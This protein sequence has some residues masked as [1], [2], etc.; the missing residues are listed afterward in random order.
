MAGVRLLLPSRSNGQQVHN[1]SSR[2]YT[3]NSRRSRHPCSSI[4]LH[5]PHGQQVHRRPHA[6]SHDAAEPITA[7]RPSQ[8]HHRPPN[9]SRP[10][11]QQLLPRLKQ[12]PEPCQ[13]EDQAA[14]SR[15]PTHTIPNP[16]SRHRTPAAAS[17]ISLLPKPSVPSSIQVDDRPPYVAS[18]QPMARA[19]SS[20]PSKTHHHR[21]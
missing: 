21:P 6:C 14:R 18:V 19:R 8:T 17:A 5:P 10:I 13:H 20:R 1:S 16:S 11:Q 9:T 15:C 12:R 2:L 3:P 7:A 4:L